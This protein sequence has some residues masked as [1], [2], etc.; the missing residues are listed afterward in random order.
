MS[1]E[2]GIRLGHGITKSVSEAAL[3]RMSSSK[4]YRAGLHMQSFRR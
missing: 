2:L 4:V 1:V 3:T